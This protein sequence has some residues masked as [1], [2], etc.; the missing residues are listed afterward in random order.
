MLNKDFKL[1][2]NKKSTSLDFVDL[3]VIYNGKLNK[4]SPKVLNADP[5][6]EYGG[7]AYQI[8]DQDNKKNFFYNDF[9]DIDKRTKETKDVSIT[10]DIRDIN[11]INPTN[12]K[13]GRFSFQFEDVKMSGGKPNYRRILF[14]YANDTKVKTINDYFSEA[15]TIEFD[16][17]KMKCFLDKDGLPQGFAYIYDKSKTYYYFANFKDGKL[18][19]FLFKFTSSN[20]KYVFKD[21]SIYYDDYKIN[22]LKEPID[23][24][25]QYNN[26][27]ELTVISWS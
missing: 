25:K 3:E 7:F 10:F 12:N 1:D 20:N 19:G 17:Y 2:F 11:S 4:K 26:N 13:N 27:Y 15:E 8:I 16:T 24:L 5:N 6:I 18:H 14:F 21:V 22:L 9:I 23:R